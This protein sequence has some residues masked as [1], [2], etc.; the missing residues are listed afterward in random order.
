ML[1]VPDG[2]EVRILG[3]ARQFAELAGPWLSRD[4]FSTTGIG[5]QLDGVISGSIPAGPDD[6]WVAVLE[7]KRVVGAAMHPPPRHLFLPRL[8]PG[9]P[10][11]VAL[12]LAGTGRSIPG[13]FGAAMAARE[14]VETWIERMGGSSSLR[15]RQRMYRVEKVTRPAITSGHAQT[16]G[17]DERDLV[18]EWFE[19]FHAEATPYRTSEGL[20]ATVERRIAAAELWLWWDSGRPVSVAGHH[21]PAAGVARVGPV[22]TP[23][24]HRRHGYATAVTASATEAALG[25]GARH[26]VLYT[27][28][29]NPTANSIYQALGFMPDHDAEEWSLMP[30]S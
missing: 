2:L 16:A 11:Q 19:G 25:M 21:P 15:M 5:V 28:L 20:A 7:R 13:V 14:F 24:A 4:P 27:D 8:S 1:T 30:A 12:W 10:S 23:P 17:A 22:Y 9:V 26:V 3:D 18:V 6:I 29:A